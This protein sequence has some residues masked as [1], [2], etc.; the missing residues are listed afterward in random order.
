[1]NEARRALLENSGLEA[2][3][4]EDLASYDFNEEITRVDEIEEDIADEEQNKENVP[5]ARKRKE[6]SC[7]KHCWR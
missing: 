6:R 7:N 3:G 2:I 4:G 1:M 5:G